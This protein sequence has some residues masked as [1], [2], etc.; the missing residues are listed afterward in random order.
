MNTGAPQQ[1]HAPQLN[2]WPAA[3]RQTMA[4]SPMGYTPTY[5]G[6][7]IVQARP[8]MRQHMTPSGPVQAHGPMQPWNEHNSMMQHQVGQ[9][10]HPMMSPMMMNP[11]MM[12]PMNSMINPMMMQMLMGQQQMLGH[13]QS[14][15]NS[16]PLMSQV[17][18]QPIQRKD[19]PNRRG[20]QL[21]PVKATTPSERSGRSAGRASQAAAS[22]DGA[23]RAQIKDLFS[24]AVNNRHKQV[25]ELFAMG[26]SPDT[27]DEHGN[28]VLHVAAQNGN[29]KL[30][31]ATLRWGANINAQNTQGQ[32]P[33]HYLFAYKYEE[34]AAYLISKG[35]DDSIQNEHGYTCYDGL[36]PEE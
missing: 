19:A 3:Q 16:I 24:K 23:S 30:I 11:M 4:P 7:R 36:R 20:S 13:G 31:K 1:Q 12:N 33:L 34:L 26:V 10:Q 8:P 25:E 28:T 35:A 5:T 21:N 27:I 17:G 2:T 15:A 18:A 22:E 29:K 14:P 6:H 9:P 32:T